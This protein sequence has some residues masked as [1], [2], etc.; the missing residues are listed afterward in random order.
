M[1]YHH[2][3]ITF[4]A[5]VTAEQREEGLEYLRAQ[6]RIDAV[7]SF[8]VGKEVGGDYAWGA[9]FVIENLDDYWDYLTDP[10]HVR[11]IEFGAPLLESL[12]TYDTTDDPDP[13]IGEKIALLQE[14]F[15][16][17]PGSEPLARELPSYKA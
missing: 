2:N 8:V 7:K 16:K 9:V 15:A 17:Q 11:T 4:R 3:R 10:A 1:I 14:R 13:E 6:G 12:V 5:G